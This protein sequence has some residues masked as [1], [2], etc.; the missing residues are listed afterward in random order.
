MAHWWKEIMMLLLSTLAG[1][2]VFVCIYRLDPWHKDGVLSWTQ[3]S[4][5]CIS[6]HLDRL[7]LK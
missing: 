6:M 4:T 1:A 5:W 7:Q 3:V 2:E